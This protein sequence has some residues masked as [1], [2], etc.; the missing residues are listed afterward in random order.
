VREVITEGLNG[1]LAPFF[2]SQRV[3][4]SVAQQ[5]EAARGLMTGRSDVYRSAPRYSAAAGVRGF[6]EL[7]VRAGAG[8]SVEP[9]CADAAGGPGRVLQERETTHGATDVRCARTDARGI[10]NRS[11]VATA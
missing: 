5:L 3:A 4:D 10:G 8:R 2:D 11:E 6:E 1:A 9:D 7:I